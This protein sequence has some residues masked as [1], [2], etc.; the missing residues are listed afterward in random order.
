MSKNIIIVTNDQY[1][2]DKFM[3]TVYANE[4]VNL[5]SEK[6]LD[7][8]DP[9][10]HLFGA[11]KRSVDGV[12]TEIGL[13]KASDNEFAIYRVPISGFCYMMA[14]ARA[15]QDQDLSMIVCIKELNPT[16]LYKNEGF[17]LLL[18][19]K[20]IPTISLFREWFESATS[21]S[22]LLPEYDWL[23]EMAEAKRIPLLSDRY[24]RIRGSE[25]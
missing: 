11:W 23:Y 19:G 14:K 21:N 2:A 6:I 4:H 16:M 24:D 17:H 5:V 18:D 7:E 13:Y 20:F 12:E 22:L 10:E 25:V 9:D 8:T 15:I 1:I 3:A